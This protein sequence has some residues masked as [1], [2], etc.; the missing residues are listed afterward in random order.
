MNTKQKFP[1]PRTA[2]LSLFTL[3]AMATLTPFYLPLSWALYKPMMLPPD[4]LALLRSPG[5]M[6]PT[7]MFVRLTPGPYCAPY[8]V[9][10]PPSI[11][12]LLYPYGLTDFPPMQRPPYLDACYSRP[13][14]FYAPTHMYMRPYFA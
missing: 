5:P 10:M 2:L 12:R 4:R 14:P 13:L 7:A 8:V 1:L 11:A 3:S 6:P 9:P